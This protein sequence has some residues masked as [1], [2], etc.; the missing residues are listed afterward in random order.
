MKTASEHLKHQ[1]IFQNLTFFLLIF[2]LIITK[3]ACPK[4]EQ[5]GT[6]GKSRLS[7]EDPAPN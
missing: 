5:T 6:L 4:K 7:S 3:K 2:T 1:P